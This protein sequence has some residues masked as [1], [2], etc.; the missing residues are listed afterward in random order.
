M[1]S[2]DFEQKTLEQELQLQGI[3]GTYLYSI[4]SQKSIDSS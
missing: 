3:M 4:L 1:Q 2:S